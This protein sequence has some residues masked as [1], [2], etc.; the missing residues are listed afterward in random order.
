MSGLLQHLSQRPR[1]HDDHERGQVLVLTALAMLL[2]LGMSAVGIDMASWYQRHH[3][4]QVAADAAAL[5]AANCMANVG[6]TS[7][8]FTDQCTTTTDAANIATT[9]AA[10]NGVTIPTSDVSFGNGTVTVTTP[11]AAPPLFAGVF[12]INSV[13]TADSVATWN[14]PITNSCGASQ[15]SS[16]ACYFAFAMDRNCPDV[17]MTLENNGNVKITGGIWSNSDLSTINVDNNSSW[18]NVTYGNGSLCSWLGASVGSGSGPKFTSGPT[19]AAALTSWPRD[20]RTVLPC[21]AADTYQC[22]GPSGTPSYCTQAAPAFGNLLG[23]DTSIPLAA[24]AG[25]VSAGQVYCAYGTSTD[26]SDPTTWNGAIDLSAST[27]T[28]T[29]MSDSFIGGVVDVTTQGS[30]TLNAALTTSLGNL[31]VYANDSLIPA[32][33]ITTQGSS[34][35]TGDIFVPNGEVLASSGGSAGYTSFVEANQVVIDA[36]GGMTGDGPATGSS[37]SSSLPGAD[38]LSG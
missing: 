20:Y 14:A 28:K 23:F 15:V 7:A 38:S 11:D 17:G 31:L 34:G 3:Q 2:L 25:S 30:V 21:G 6:V 29:G 18:G 26:H 24:T 12:G 32:A 16:G 36:S 5:A 1:R 9:L 8:T 27:T 13:Q 10:A 22:T 19:P 4:A 35:L 33:T 37:G